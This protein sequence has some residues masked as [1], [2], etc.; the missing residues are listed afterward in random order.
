MAKFCLIQRGTF[1]TQG[2]SI[3][4]SKSVIEFDHMES[5]EFEWDALPK[6]YRRL[7]YNFNEYGFFHTKIYT[8]DH[9]ELFIFCKK[10]NSAKILEEIKVFIDNP[11]PLKEHSALE[12]VPKSTTID[13][14]KTNFWWCIDINNVY[15]D[16]IA[17]LESHINLIAFA[18]RN[19]YQNI[20][21]KKSE[22]DR[23]EEYRKSLVW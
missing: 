18:L 23:K 22:A 8:Q 9:N 6:A 11:Y 21:M 7:M 12:K 16:W 17:F 3:S 1:K 2:S 15:G 5:S 13:D 20:W 4:G 19:D 14:L 10:N